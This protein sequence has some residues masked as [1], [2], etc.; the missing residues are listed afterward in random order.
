MLCAHY[1]RTRLMSNRPDSCSNDYHN[2]IIN[3]WL[4]IKY[5]SGS[6]TCKI[7]KCVAFCFGKSTIQ[8]FYPHLDIYTHE[9][10]QNKIPGVKFL[11]LLSSHDYNIN[12]ILNQKPHKFFTRNVYYYVT[13]KFPV[14]MFWYALR[15]VAATSGQPDQTYLPPSN[16]KYRQVLWN[17]EHLYIIQQYSYWKLKTC[18]VS[19]S[20]FTVLS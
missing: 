10:C 18:T 17:V 3:D 7:P 19:H 15:K 4:P 6:Q 5:Q 11:D 8:L 1:A 20:T 14:A 9:D 2:S 12:E 16:A 13:Y